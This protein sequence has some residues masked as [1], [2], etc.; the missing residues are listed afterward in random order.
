MATVD[1]KTAQRAHGTVAEAIERKRLFRQ[2]CEVCG[3][4]KV[5]AH[6]DDYSKPLDVKWLCPHHHKALHKAIGPRMKR[7]ITDGNVIQV[8]KFPTELLRRI[9]MEMIER[10][11]T[12]AQFLVVAVVEFLKGK[13]NRENLQSN[14]FRR[15]C[16][17]EGR[18]CRRAKSATCR[19]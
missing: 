18:A 11:Q 7:E 19:P 13:K 8:R 10:D 6:H 17:R 12:L 14:L 4:T 5:Q 1:Y 16:E 15:Q 3:R 9:K 2:P